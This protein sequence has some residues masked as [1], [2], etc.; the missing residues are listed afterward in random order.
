MLWRRQGVAQNAKGHCAEVP[1]L[2]SFVIAACKLT[3][4]RFDAARSKI[5]RQ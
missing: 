3:L 5:R 1:A 4:L 2:V